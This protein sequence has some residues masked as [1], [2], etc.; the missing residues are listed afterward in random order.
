MNP[1]IQHERTGLIHIRAR[2][3]LPQL[4][5]NPGNIDIFPAI[6][7]I[8]FL[9]GRARQHIDPEHSVIT[10][11]KHGPTERSLEQWLVKVSVDRVAVNPQYTL[12]SLVAWPWEVNGKIYNNNNNNNNK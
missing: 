5:Q 12:A 11:A 7:E 10:R 6:G 1:S 9:F 2:D 4:A 3:N 8:H